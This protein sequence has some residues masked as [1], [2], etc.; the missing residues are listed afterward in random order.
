[1]LSLIPDTRSRN[2]YK[3]TCT[4]LC[5]ASLCNFFLYTFPAEQLLHKFTSKVDKKTRFHWRHYLLGYRGTCPLDFQLLFFQVTSEP[6]KI[7]Q[8]TSCKRLSGKNIQTY[9]CVTFYCMNFSV[10]LFSLSFAL[11]HS[12]QILATPLH[13]LA[14][15]LDRVSRVLGAHRV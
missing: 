4:S 2:L 11:S 1:M 3:S 12:H 8:S 5:H 10:K 6:H 13:V 15:F 7:W 14:K 9:N